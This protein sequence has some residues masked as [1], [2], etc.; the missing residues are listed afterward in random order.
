MRLRILAACLAAAAVVP[1]LAPS[2][3][4]ALTQPGGRQSRTSGNAIAGGNVYVASSRTSENTGSGCTLAF[5]VRSISTGKKGA[6]TAGHCVATLPGGAPYLVQQ[7]ESLSGD[8]T[9]PGNLLGRI[10]ASNYRL[11]EDGDNAFVQLA[12]HVSTAPLMYVGGARSHTTI[13][14]AGVG[15]L[16]TGT[17]VCYSG[18]ATG[19]H[20]GFT[21]VGGSQRVSFVSAHHH[22]VEIAHEWRATGASCTSR[23]GDSGSPVY[24]RVDGVAYAVGILSGGQVKAGT[25]PFYFTPVTLALKELG[26]KLIKTT[27]S[28]G[29]SF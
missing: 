4:G 17:E 18:A 3:A 25:C 9:A 27:P 7:T 10:T 28:T 23:R 15:K 8:G 2:G 24:T 12:R 29:S 20:C 22:K 5:A 26:L 19:E 1:M 11:G 21:V 16:D 13:P 6:L 14:V